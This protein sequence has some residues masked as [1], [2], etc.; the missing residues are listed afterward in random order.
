MNTYDGATLAS[1][2]LVEAENERQ[3]RA[4][5]LVALRDLYAERQD[6]TSLAAQIEIRTVRLATPEEI[7]LCT[8]HHESL[9]REQR[10]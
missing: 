7:E 3:A 5:G 6:R 8:W 1:Y 2:V 10:Q 4:Q 9:K